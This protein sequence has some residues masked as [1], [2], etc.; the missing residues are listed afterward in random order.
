MQGLYQ[1]PLYYEIAFG[2]RNI[3]KEVDLLEISAKTYA[4]ITIR[5]FLEIGCGNGP[6]MEELLERGYEYFGI[7]L[8]E[9]MLQFSSD[10]AKKLGQSV[11]LF[12]KDMVNFV[13]EQQVDFVYVM[14]GSL[15][16]QNT[17]ELHSHFDSVSKVLRSGGL[18]LLDWC[19]QFHT[20]SDHT[21]Y[22]TREQNGI[23]VKTTYLSRVIN[24][25]LQTFEE[26]I[27]LEV[28]D[29]GNRIEIND[30]CVKRAIYPQEFLFFISLR[31]DF[32][33]VGWWNDWNLSAPLNGNDAINRPIILLKKRETNK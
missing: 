28:D 1:N 33:F 8:S 25:L 18:Y 10:K 21:D 5:R 14:L 16:T 20:I 13:L 29:H 23:K 6:H 4:D 7:D 12:R 17:E 30:K 31:S 19:V 9:E 26:M 27:I 22:W 15:Y 11:G 32:E 2:F 24:P 3:S